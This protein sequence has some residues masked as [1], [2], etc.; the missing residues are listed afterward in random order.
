[1]GRDSEIS[2][3]AWAARYAF[4]KNM[5][6]REFASFMLNRHPDAAI[7]PI[8][9]EFSAFSWAA[10]PDGYMMAAW[11]SGRTGYP[12]VDAAMRQLVAEGWAHNRMRFLAASFFCKYLLLPWPAGAAWMVRTL[13]DA[14]EASNSLGWQWTAGC[15]SD[16]F[17]FTTL[18]NPSSAATRSLP[19]RRRR[20]RAN[21]RA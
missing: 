14:D 6:L 7:K 12:V 21:V 9:P 4:L 13:V 8:V 15:N 17:P 20:L 5:A 16:A 2:R 18:V 11:E 1:M 19:R 3:R 10:D